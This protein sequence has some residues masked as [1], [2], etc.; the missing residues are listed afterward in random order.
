MTTEE[1]AYPEHRLNRSLAFGMFAGPAAW[2]LHQQ[3]SYMLTPTVCANGNE[4]VLHL[5]ALLALVL[6]AAGGLVAWRISKRL[7][8]GSTEKGDDRGT[9]ARFLALTAAVLCAFFGLVILAQ[10]VPNLFL[11]ACVS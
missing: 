8:E 3:V 9:R 6:T 7:P 10:E 11:G 2:A 4:F 1:Q 5:V